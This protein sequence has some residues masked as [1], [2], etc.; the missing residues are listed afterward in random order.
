M[1]PTIIIFL[2]DRPLHV[3]PGATLGRVLAEFEPDLYAAMLGGG[4]VATDGRA[5]PVD[6][7]SVV[8]AGSIY[9]VRRSARG[10]AADA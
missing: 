2:N 4:A 8:S 3:A 1:T 5:V 6:G 9:R 10:G 7:D